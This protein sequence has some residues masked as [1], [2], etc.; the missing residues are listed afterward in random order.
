MISNSQK[1]LFSAE[2]FPPADA[3]L[4]QGFCTGN[5]EGFGGW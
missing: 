1:N 5:I 2:I 4:M 3:N